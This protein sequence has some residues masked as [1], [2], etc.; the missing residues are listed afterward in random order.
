[1]QINLTDMNIQKGIHA[2]RNGPHVVV[3]LSFHELMNGPEIGS[4]LDQFK[5]AIGE[6]RRVRY[7]MHVHF[8]NLDETSLIAKMK[9]E[10]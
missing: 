3:D 9:G 10:S 7:P 8:T 6:M 2:I 1:M 5:Y 4:L